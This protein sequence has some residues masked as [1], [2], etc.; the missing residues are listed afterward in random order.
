MKANSMKVSQTVRVG[1]YA[2]VSSQ[3]QAKS[4]T[5]DSQIETIKKHIEDKGETIFSDLIFIDDGFTGSTLLRPALERLRDTAYSKKINKVYVLSPDRLARNY[6]YQYLLMEEFKK[7]E[8]EVIFLNNSFEDNPESKLLLQV[9]GM[10][11]EYERTKI[12]E[13]NRRGKIMQQKTVR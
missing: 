11:S 9:Q 1:F 3:K 12:M 7:N 2:R 4:M 10:I 13:R 8:V 6:A 5:I